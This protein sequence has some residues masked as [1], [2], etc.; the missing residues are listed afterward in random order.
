MPR[1]SGII[2][3]LNMYSYCNTK[4]ELHEPPKLLQKIEREKIFQHFG[5]ENKLLAQIAAKLH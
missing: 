2:S 1:L 3:W 4:I 5:G